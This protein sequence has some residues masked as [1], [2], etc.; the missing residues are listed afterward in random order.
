MADL[1]GTDFSGARL[2][3]LLENPRIRSLRLAELWALGPMLKLVLLERVAAAGDLESVGRIGHPPRRHRPAAV[4]KRCLARPGGVR[5]GGRARPPRDP[6]GVY[7][8]MTFRT[9]D[10]CRHTVEAIA[11]R[12]RLDELQV[13][14]LA[15]G[16]AGAKN[17]SVA[18]FLI[19]PGLPTCARARAIANRLRRDCVSLVRC[20]PNALYFSGLLR[21]PRPSF[22][23]SGTRLDAGVV[24][25]AR[26][27][28]RC[29][30][31]EPA[32]QHGDR[33][34]H[35]AAHEFFGRYP[36][37][38]PHVCGRADVTP[39]TDEVQKLLERLEIHHL[40]NRD[41]NLFF[42]LLTDFPDSSSPQGDDRVLQSCHRRNPAS[43][44]ALRQWPQ[45]FY[46]FHRAPE[47]NEREGVWMGQERKRGKLNDFNAL[48]LGQHDG[49]AVKVGDLSILPT[50]NYV[51]T[52]DSDTQLPL[53]TAR[54]LIATMAHPLNHPVI[55]AANNTVRSRLCAAPAAHRDQHGIG[56]A[57]APGWHL[58]RPDRL[59]SLYHRR[60]RRLSGPLG[61]GQLYRARA[62]TTCARSTRR[63][64]SAFPITRCSAMISSKGEHA[65]TG[66]VTD[67]EVIDD[68]P[69]TYESYSQRKHRWVR[70][71]WQ[72]ASLALRPGSEIR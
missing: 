66:L 51:I 48:L 5:V 28:G 54:E 58:Q 42:A 69:T 70:G 59:R 29:H 35:L 33:A 38:L 16:L 17:R 67:L 43:E 64:V 72:I 9:R 25:V 44:P 36:A 55:D 56:F 31:D 8:R 30:L 39:V 68:Y 61:T 45:P 15:L 50:I 22:T 27:P 10:D 1:A 60:L 19:G 20:Y 2:K 21:S 34:A 40:A 18:H 14:W 52:L 49:F 37:G 26:Q 12:S 57:L 23:S 32:G 65:R 41:P 71:D 13:A 46:L 4:R 24:V 3:Q 47:W 62:F 7:A 53:D 6:A 11:R 63:P